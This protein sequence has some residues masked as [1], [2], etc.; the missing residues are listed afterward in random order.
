MILDSGSLSGGHPVESA[1]HS[2]LGQRSVYVVIS[3]TEAYE[4]ATA[5]K[6]NSSQKRHDHRIAASAYSLHDCQLHIAL[7]SAATR[8]QSHY[9]GRGRPRLFFSMSPLNHR[10][11]K[12]GGQGDMSPPN[13]M[14]GGTT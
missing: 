12:R 3:V 2:K 13:N 10:R 7:L 14:I 11:R 5:D 4:A 9:I 8:P 1:G 6:P